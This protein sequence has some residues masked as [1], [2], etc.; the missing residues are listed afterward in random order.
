ML[1]NNSMCFYLLANIG[2]QVQWRPDLKLSASLSLR[3][4]MSDSGVPSKS[5]LKNTRGTPNLTEAS[6]AAF[7]LR[8]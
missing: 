4:W 2:I 5:D 8:K 6:S 3:A 7:P 1:I